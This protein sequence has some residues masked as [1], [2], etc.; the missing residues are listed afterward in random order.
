MLSD[1]W[2]TI[3]KNQGSEFIKKYGSFGTIYQLRAHLQE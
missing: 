1:F 3:K 2:R